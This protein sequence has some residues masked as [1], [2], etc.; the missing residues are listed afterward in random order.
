MRKKSAVELK[1]R[2][3]EGYASA[4]KIASTVFNERPCSSIQL[5]GPD[6]LVPATKTAA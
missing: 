3:N 1:I 5:C 4:S 2:Y 6:L